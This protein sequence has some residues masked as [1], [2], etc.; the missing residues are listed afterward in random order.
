LAKVNRRQ[1]PRDGKNSHCLYQGE[2]KT[3]QIKKKLHNS[4]TVVIK[5]SL[6]ISLKSIHSQAILVSDWLICKNV[7]L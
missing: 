4:Y 6:K 2:L 3:L 1:T 5:E 7:L